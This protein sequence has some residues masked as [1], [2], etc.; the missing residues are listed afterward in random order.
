LKLAKALTFGVFSLKEVKDLYDLREAL[1]VYAVGVAELTPG[2]D[3]RSAQSTQRTR[4][5]LKANDKP[6]PHR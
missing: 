2:I 5:L 1:E 6:R 3:C 4:K